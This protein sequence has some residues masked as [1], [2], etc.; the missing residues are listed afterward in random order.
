M[1]R[2][3]LVSAVWLFVVAF[4]AGCPTDDDDDA[5]GPVLDDDNNTADDDDNND[6]ADDDDDDNNDD[7]NDNNDDDNDDDNDDNDDNDDDNDDDDNDTTVPELGWCNIQHPFEM[8]GAEGVATETVYGRIYIAG[9]TGSGTPLP[10][11]TV[12]LGYG[13]LGIDPSA[14]P[15]NY[16]WI[17]MAFNYG[18]TGDN[19]DEYQQALTIADGD[20]YAYAIRVTLDDGGGW[21]YCDTDEGTANGFAV[22]DLGRVF[23]GND[24][25]DWCDLQWPAAITVAAGDPTELIYGQVYIPGVTGQGSP[26]VELRAR[27]GYGPIDRDP[28]TWP[29]EFVWLAATF[30]DAHTG[31]DNDEFMRTLTVNL[32]G[33]YHYLYRFS[34]DSGATWTYCDFDPGTS[35]GFSLDDLGDLTVTMAK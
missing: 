31:D 28:R 13:E 9:E 10:Y 32:A 5:G 27:V 17:E 4:L 20:T 15:G 24:D 21:T 2:L 1:S 34:Y 25:I 30:N 29:D 6:A 33:E 3:T 8:I 18:H 11:V 19:N 35:D 22:E 23:I 26:A 7:D 16:E 14:T 12:Q